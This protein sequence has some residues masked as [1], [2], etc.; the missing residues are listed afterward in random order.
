ML[1]GGF[2]SAEFQGIDLTGAS[3]DKRLE[4]ETELLRWMGIDGDW[5]EGK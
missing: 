4:E 5:G 2:E 3:V 1:R